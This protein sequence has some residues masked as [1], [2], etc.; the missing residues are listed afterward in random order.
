MP[1][2]YILVRQGLNYS[3]TFPNKYNPVQATY[4]IIIGSS[5]PLLIILILTYIRNSF[6][7]YT[8]PLNCLT[9]GILTN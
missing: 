4:F 1:F 5:S 6:N 3:N 8:S 9:N 2:T 7:L